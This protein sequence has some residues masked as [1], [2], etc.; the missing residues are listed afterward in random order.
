MPR[1]YS[2]F[3]TASQVAA[4][5]L[6][7]SRRGR[8]AQIIVYAAIVIAILV[9]KRDWILSPT[10]TDIP[11]CL[12]RALDAE[13]AVDAAAKEQNVRAVAA[14]YDD[15]AHALV[16]CPR[17]NR[18]HR[19]RDIRLARAEAAAWRSG[20]RHFTNAPLPRIVR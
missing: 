13:S 11:P 4:D 3:R 2:P 5:R 16:G 6:D 17:P 19:D 20:E 8:T 7:E 14:A 12:A 15:G 10:V 18:N 1:E 9:W